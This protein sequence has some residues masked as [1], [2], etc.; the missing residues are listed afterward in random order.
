MKTG[1]RLIEQDRLVVVVIDDRGRVIRQ[2]K[3]VPEPFLLSHAERRAYVKEGL[4][5]AVAFV[6]DC[7]G[8]SL[9]EAK[10]LVDR[11]RRWDHDQNQI[12]F[13]R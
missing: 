8:I 11:A 6:R 13:Q 3:R 1:C 2:G 9:R 4:V 5:K 12:R 10:D 7:R